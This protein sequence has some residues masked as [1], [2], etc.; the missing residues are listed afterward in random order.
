MLGWNGEKGVDKSTPIY[1]NKEKRE[2]TNM[3][4]FGIHHKHC[5]MT[6]IIFGYNYADACR[7]AKK[8]PTMWEVEYQEYVD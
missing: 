4:E 7:R 2:V 3:Y 6:T 8:D 5:G 1:Y